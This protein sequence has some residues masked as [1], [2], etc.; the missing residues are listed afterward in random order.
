MEH[1]VGCVPD[2]GARQKPFRQGR[3]RSL[4]TASYYLLPFHAG[5][6]SPPPRR[7]LPGADAMRDG[8]SRGAWGWIGE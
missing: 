2:Q 1:T 6:D 3:L 5:Q 7:R 8:S 4:R